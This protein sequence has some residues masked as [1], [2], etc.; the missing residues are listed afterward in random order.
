MTDTR[1]LDEPGD[2]AN[3]LLSEGLHAVPVQQKRVQARHLHAQLRHLPKGTQNE[4]SDEQVSDKGQQHWRT[5][6]QLWNMLS[7][8][9]TSVKCPAIALRPAPAHDIPLLRIVIFVINSI[10]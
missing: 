3:Y 4:Y 10:C 2:A 5:S 1:A 6:T 7:W 9:S 8:R